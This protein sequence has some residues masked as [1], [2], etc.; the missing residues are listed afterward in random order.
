MYRYAL[1]SFSAFQL[2]MQ[3]YDELG[4]LNIN[5]LLYAHR[6]MIQVQDV[7]IANFMFTGWNLTPEYTVIFTIT[8][9][10]NRP[11][12]YLMGSV[13]STKVIHLSLSTHLGDFDFDL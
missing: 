13:C 6:A 1:V 10:V 9:L 12:L 5:L 2:L 3:Q 4:F 7:V 8:P 11:I